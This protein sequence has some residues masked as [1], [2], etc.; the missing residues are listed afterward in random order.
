MPH[1]QSPI[2]RAVT[3]LAEELD[4]MVIAEGAETLD[5]VERL[6]QLNCKMVQGFAFGPVLTGPELAK[7]LLAQLGR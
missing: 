2:I 5:E 7:K 6:R 3:A 1:T 4:M